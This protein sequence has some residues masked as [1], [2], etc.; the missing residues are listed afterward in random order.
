MKK[1]NNMIATLVFLVLILTSFSIV[2]AVDTTKNVEIKEAYYTIFSGVGNNQVIDIEY[3]NTNNQANAQIYKNNNTNAQIFKLVKNTDGTYTI[4]NK[5]SGKVLDIEYGNVF[6]GANVWQYEKNGTNA[7]KWILEDAG[8]GY[9][10][11]VSKLNT[12]YCLDVAFGL[13]TN[14]TNLQVYEKN[15]S[16]AQKFLLKEKPVKES[17]KSVESGT[18]KIVSSIDATK[19]LDVEFGLKTTGAN[20]QLYTD[21]GT[22]AQQF[23]I[24]YG[25][26]GYY[27]IVNAN[28]KKPVTAKENNFV[29]GGNIFQGD[30]IKSDAQKWIIEKNTDGTYT[31]FSKQSELCIDVYDGKAKDGNNIWEHN[32]NGTAA[33]KFFLVPIEKIESKQVLKNGEYNIKT[34]LNEAK[35]IDVKDSSTNSEAKLL[36]IEQNNA[37]SQR[38]E[39]KYGSDG[40]YTIINKNSK[41]AI[42]IEWANKDA[43][44][45]VWQYAVNNTDAQKW[46]LKDLG[47]GYY[48]IISKLNGLYLTVDN[49]NTATGMRLKMSNPTNNKNQKFKLSEYVYT[50]PQKDAIADGIY[51]IYAKNNKVLEV[52]EASYNNSANIHIWDNVKGQ[53]QKFMVKQIGETGYY[54]ITNINSGKLLEVSWGDI[55]ANANVAQYEKNNTDAQKWIIKSCGDGYYNI[56]C[57]CNNLALHVQNNSSTNGTNVKVYFKNGTDSQKFKFQKIEIITKDTYQIETSLN[58]NKVLDVAGAGQEDGKNVQLYD[59]NNTDAQN[60]TLEYDSNG[61]YTIKAKHSGKVLTVDTKTNNVYQST[62]KS[63][64]NQKW[65]IEPAGNGYYYIISKYNQYCLN[66]YNSK[67]ANETNINVSKKNN[68]S[69]QK[70]KFFKGF[71]TFFEEGAY[72]VS[73]L[74]TSGDG[75]G[76]DLKYYKFGRG[77]NVLFATYSIHGFEDSYSHDGSELTY[78]AEQF[79]NNLQNTT[80]ADIINNWTIYILPK[81]NPDGQTY[82]WTNNGPGRN[83]LYSAAP[84]NKAIDMN[85]CWQTETS[86]TRYYDD[87]NYN[88]TAPYQAYE[89][90]ALRDFLLSHKSSSGQ[91]I[92]VDLHGWLNET[93]GDEGL[94]KY[95]R[96]QYNMSTHIYSYGKGYLVN[97][98]RQSL[99]NGNKTARSVLVELPEVSSHQEVLNKDYAKKYITATLNM[100]RE[101]G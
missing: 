27:N 71:R 16:K 63:Q 1:L 43:G 74:K 50:A 11:L 76:T 44:A 54:E 57:K 69:A 91:T 73:G 84:E 13:N 98:A 95:Y 30:K 70:F 40:Y 34:N 100:L 68:S 24:T 47:N 67:T 25:T 96:T 14:G 56:I 48:N 59:A 22:K 72:G 49:S 6:N 83:T 28:S 26:D 61:E 17:K 88:G 37:I 5:N 90:R 31:I 60:F 51:Q 82:G 23:E 2:N 46:I 65:I 19:V 33:Q 87:R 64:N 93:I 4:V 86:Y 36:I 53:Q 18:Y 97:W 10:Y 81:L 9:Y 77:S 99:G 89:A 42:D 78:I 39:F 35:V 80:D 62:N 8:N 3:G 15:N 7:Q 85:R 12:K 58:S 20:I 92:L 79:K 29:A 55:K 45:Y 52:A 75:R 94:G 32:S 101:N 21:N 41:K 38:F 66:V